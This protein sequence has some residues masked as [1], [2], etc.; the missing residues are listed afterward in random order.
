ME[1]RRLGRSDIKVSVLSLGCWAM[2]GGP[3]WG[4]LDESIYIA[5]VHKALD[6]G[7]N[8]FDTAEMYGNGRS[9]QVLGKALADRREKAI[10][11]SKIAPAHTAPATL[12]AHCEASLRRLRT[13]YIDVYMIHWP[14]RDRPIAEVLATM[15]DLKREGKIR[16]IGVSNFGVQQLSEAL[17]TGV[18]ID[19][20]QL[21]YSLLSRAIEFE[22]L[23]LC[24]QHQVGVTAYMPLMQG[25]LA[26]R[27][28]TPDQVPPFRARTRHFSS[29][30]PQ[31][32]HGEPGAEKEMFAAL[33]AI[34][35]IATEM[36]VPMAELALA[37]VISRPGVVSAISG[38]RKPEHVERNVG[39]A[40]LHL[41]PEVIARLDQATEVLKQKLGP[42]AD[43][44]QSGENSRIR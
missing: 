2:G 41:S 44:W 30:R 28:R 23:P 9:E 3:G 15:E 8:F 14:V 35:E 17:A 12:R 11:G 33:D 25:L 34:R 5:T 19:V 32:R 31:A 39:A 13:D 10:I 26:G 42:N 7:I 38:A 18:Q 29:N 40:S 27:Y 4:E 21:S 24:R 22:I 20:N 37:W 43:Y 1:K 16:S 36:D 6:V